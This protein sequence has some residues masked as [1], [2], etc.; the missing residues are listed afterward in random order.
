M[1]WQRQVCLEGVQEAGAL[2]R[3]C[4]LQ[5]ALQSLGPAGEKRP[6]EESVVGTKATRWTE[7]TA[8]GENGHWV[9]TGW[10]WITG[11]SRSRQ[12]LV[13]HGPRQRESQKDQSEVKGCLG[14]QQAAIAQ[15]GASQETGLQ[16]KGWS[17]STVSWDLT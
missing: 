4:E 9:E 5:G 1:G 10:D 8:H 7:V 12:R 15:G 2:P 16:K 17:G 14:E 13:P 11:N 3:V 6:G